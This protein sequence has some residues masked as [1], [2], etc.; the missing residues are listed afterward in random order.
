MNAPVF[1]DMGISC[2]LHPLCKRTWHWQYTLREDGYIEVNM[3]LEN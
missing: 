1:V 3:E 2:V